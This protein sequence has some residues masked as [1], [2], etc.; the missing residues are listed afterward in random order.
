MCDRAIKRNHYEVLGVSP[1]SSAEEIR[2]A[3]RRLARQHH[4]DTSDIANSEHAMAEINRAWS[5]LSDPVQ[6]FDYDHSLRAEKTATQSTRRAAEESVDVS[7]PVPVY[8]A[9]FPWR[10]ILF[11]GVVAVVVVLVM[12]ALAKPVGPEVPDN[13]LVTGSCVE[14]DAE[15]FVKEVSCLTAHDGTVRQFVAYDRNCPS[16]TMGYLDRQGMGIA[17][18]EYSSE[19]PGGGDRVP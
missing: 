15:Q 17:C 1:S 19:G 9:R 5:V 12:H 14:I 7:R 16:D 3:F 6:R 13:L 18:V 11:F 2:T 10:G 8:P 4:P